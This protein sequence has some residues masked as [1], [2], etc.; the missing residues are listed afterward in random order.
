MNSAR[1]SALYDNAKKGTV[2]SGKGFSTPARTIDAVVAHFQAEFGEGTVAVETETEAARL[3]SLGAKAVVA[4]GALRAFV[5]E[6]NGSYI[7]NL[8]KLQT[9]SSVKH[10]WESLTDEE[11]YVYHYAHTVV[12][13]E[14]GANGILATVA[15]FR[16][17]NCLGRAALY[18]GTVEIARKVLT[19][20]S[21]KAAIVATIRVLVHE[22][23]HVN[24]K[25]GDG[26]AAHT[27]A[28]EVLWMKIYDRQLGV[29]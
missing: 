17:E 13:T 28:V 27:Q 6:R 2:D 14:M 16:D 21:R 12:N 29:G 25:A 9:E 23:A 5:E 19:G 22:F 8:H 1:A 24:S 11:Q 26:Q 20:V 15:D 7:S 3:R 4:S 18:G 10:A